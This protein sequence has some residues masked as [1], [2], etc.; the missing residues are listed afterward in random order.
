MT[1]IISRGQ[2]MAQGL[3]R[4]FTGEKCAN[5]G[6]AERRVSDRHCVCQQCSSS[7]TERRRPAKKVYHRKNRARLVKITLRWIK[8]NPERAAEQRKRWREENPDKVVASHALR[9]ASKMM[10][11]PPWYGELDEFA[12][13]ELASLC[14]DREKATGIT[15]QVDHMIPLQARKACGLHTALNLQVIPKTM[16]LGKLNKMVFTRP[17]EW[18]RAL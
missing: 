3:K 4:Y 13:R 5:G 17:D 12:M 11:T 8:E 15:W 18:L 2:A 10:A 6:L 16:N 9:R 14:R 7:K 1:Q